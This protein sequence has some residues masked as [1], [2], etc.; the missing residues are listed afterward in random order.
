MQDQ[1]PP[2]TGRGDNFRLVLGLFTRLPVGD[3]PVLPPG[4]L[5]RAAWAFP[6]AGA[7]AGLFAG[8]CVLV[9]AEVGLGPWLLALVAIAAELIVTGA[10]HEDGFA[11]IADGLGGRDAEARLRIMRDSRIGVFGSAALWL[12]LTARLVLL[13][14]IA[15]GGV[16]ALVFAL[17]AANAGARLALLLPLLLLDPARPDGLGA[18][19]GRVPGEAGWTAVVYAA[20]IGLVCLGWGV[21]PAGLA[22]L[23]AG[24]VA[25]L[26]GLH[27]L[28]GYTG[29]LLGATAGLAMILI[30]LV[31]AG[32]G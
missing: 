16:W 14:G 8:L 13:A 4:S 10:F 6:L 3:L 18:S 29:D 31:A 21:V 24:V 20:G 2:K 32:H 9:G 15:G 26:F 25:T 7:A 23:A 12:N 1:L 5:G 27:R 30:L 22:V 17:V 28:G 19:V 11:D